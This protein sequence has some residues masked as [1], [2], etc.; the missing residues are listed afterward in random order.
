MATE[1]Q[2]VVFDMDG[3]IIESE[4]THYRAICEA[5][6]E[7]MKVPY[8]VFLTAF[9]PSAAWILRSRKPAFYDGRLRQ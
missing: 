4:I 3:V 1:L 6:G 9:L 5:M 2:A 7:D 8:E